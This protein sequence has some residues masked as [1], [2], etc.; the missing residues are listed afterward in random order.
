MIQYEA[1]SRGQGTNQALKEKGP[2]RE[3]HRHCLEMEASDA[4]IMERKQEDREDAEG[5][6]HC[7]SHK[8]Q[9][10]AGLEKN[11]PPSRA[12]YFLTADSRLIEFEGAPAKLGPCQSTF[13][14]P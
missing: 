1:V 9:A 13:G 11:N 7:G 6:G 2:V 4:H 12:S 8:T 3:G 14:A 10:S 5:R